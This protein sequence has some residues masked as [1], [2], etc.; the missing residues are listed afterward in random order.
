MLRIADAI[1]KSR[2]LGKRRRRL[3]D[4]AAI[5]TT[6]GDYPERSRRSYSNCIL[7]NNSNNLKKSFIKKS[8]FHL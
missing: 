3:R 8:F 5:L 6:A 7:N 1:G 2:K 4:A